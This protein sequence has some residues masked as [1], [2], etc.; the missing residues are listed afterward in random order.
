M[1]CT[2]A[3]S[4]TSSNSACR[5]RLGLLRRRKRRAAAA[6][7]P[8]SLALVVP[9][10]ATAA[11]ATPV[12]D[13]KGKG[14]E[15]VQEM[16]IHDGNAGE[17]SPLSPRR[18]EGF[19]GRVYRQQ[20]QQHQPER[21]EGEEGV[22]EEDDHLHLDA[23]RA[24]R[25][26]LLQQSE[27]Q[28]HML[29]R[30]QTRSGRL[31]THYEYIDGEWVPSD[32]WS[33]Y[34]REGPGRAASASGAAGSDSVGSSHSRPSH[35][36]ATGGTA[37][38]DDA[39][40][41]NNNHNNSPAAGTTTGDDGPTSIGWARTSNPVLGV[42]IVTSVS[43]NSGAATATAVSTS[44]GFAGERTGMSTFTDAL[45]ASSSLPT[46][47]SSA[48]TATSVGRT[49]NTSGQTYD[50][51]KDVPRGW[52]SD[53]RTKAYAVPVIVGLSVFLA[54]LIFSLI[55]LFVRSKKNRKR[56]RKQNQKDG[57]LQE[58]GKLRRGAL[59]DEDGNVPGSSSSGH[60]SGGAAS[61]VARRSSEEQ[62]ELDEKSVLLKDKKG[63]LRRIG[64][65]WSPNSSGGALRRRKTD[66]AKLFNRSGPV[67]V[68]EIK[69]A[70]SAAR[71]SPP[72]TPSGDVASLS[73][74]RT[75]STRG[76][77]NDNPSEDAP[78]ARTL[79]STS[80][81]SRTGIAAAQ[82]AR[83]PSPPPGSLRRASRPPS[84]RIDPP[85]L[86]TGSQP[87]AAADA[88]DTSSTAE[89]ADDAHQV[90]LPSVGPP[91]Y[92]HPPTPAYSR[93]TAPPQSAAGSAAGNA[94]IRAPA[95]RT[96]AEALS[97]LS[98]PGLTAGL[99][100]KRSLLQQDQA[101]PSHAGPSS[102]SDPYR[103]Q[104]RYEHLYASREGEGA[105]SEQ[106]TGAPSASSS[107]SVG[108]EGED[109]EEDEAARVQSRLA[110]HVAVDD[111]EL[112]SRINEAGSAPASAQQ[113]ALGVSA[114]APA[115]EDH[116]DDEYDAAA[117]GEDVTAAA[118]ASPSARATTLAFPLPPRPVAST[119]SP[120]TT[121]A[122]LPTIDEKARLKQMDGQLA[123]QYLPS[124]PNVDASVPS[125]PA[126]P[127]LRPAGSAPSAPELDYST[128]HASAPSAPVFELGEEETEDEEDDGETLR[129]DIE[130]DSRPFRE[131]TI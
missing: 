16:L 79:S 105:A 93:S 101:A 96:P 111:K 73:L 112:L 25:N 122:A 21:A 36:A 90:P 43:D 71:V 131:G 109:L 116:E 54:C 24:D 98:T 46:A 128:E 104:R 53:G 33:L 92:I 127:A 1:E 51:S 42:D 77:T 82:I 97:A 74:S 34:G 50:F 47:T 29:Q 66:I 8:G 114:S 10:L 83:R 126:A 13:R 64:R 37:D 17:Q 78:L 68:E 27:A 32:D 123:G 19:S 85:A 48:A 12:A 75:G 125:G 69:P 45:T 20:P 89:H 119:F 76:G 7:A 49:N 14:R 88:A 70:A 62:G 23:R 18:L 5:R 130:Q 107:R 2:C 59:P 86:S 40:F 26:A 94:Q 4:G 120:T 80:T 9:V 44:G 22:E 11:A 15:M 61:G 39:A 118:A 102:S 117:F 6:A 91:A 72:S 100:E 99:D 103:E 58:E 65:K 81:S 121:L 129:G 63:R 115:L 108:R 38:D 67:I 28:M 41:N 87:S 106:R 52:V 3:S 84:I 30:R 31:A 55:T 113:Q 124:A 56:R 35:T 110:G 95:I 60:S 57:T